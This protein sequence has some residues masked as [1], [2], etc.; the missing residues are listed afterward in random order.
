MMNHRILEKMVKISSFIFNLLF[1]S[2]FYIPFVKKYFY[3]WNR[4]EWKSWLFLFRMKE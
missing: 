3:S 1:F 2:Q 4:Q